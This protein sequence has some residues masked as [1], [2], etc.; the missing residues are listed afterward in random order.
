MKLYKC[1][2]CGFKYKEKKWRDRCEDWCREHQ[3]CSLEIMNHAY[4]TDK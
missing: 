4:E 2:E 3:S 1:K